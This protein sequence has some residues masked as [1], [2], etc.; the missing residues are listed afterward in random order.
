MALGT[1]VGTLLKLPRM[2]ILMHYSWAD[3]SALQNT[4]GLMHARW[5]HSSIPAADPQGHGADLYCVYTVGT[6]VCWIIKPDL[7][8]YRKVFEDT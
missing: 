2:C 8:D 6:S 3:S 4:F 7:S 5:H 1:P